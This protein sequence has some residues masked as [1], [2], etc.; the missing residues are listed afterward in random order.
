MPGRAADAILS[1]M[2]ETDST[3]SPQ[4]SSFQRRVPEGDSRERLVC[5][6]CGFVNY[7]N[8]KI[9]VG[10]VATWEGRILLCRRAIHPRRGFWTLPAGYLELNETTA[11]GAAREAFEEACARIRIDQLL[12]VYSIPR[13]SQVQ[14]M[15]RADLVSPDVAAGEETEAV[16]LFEWDEIPWEEIAFPSVH[17]ALHHHRETRHEAAFVPR[18]NPPGETGDMRPLPRNP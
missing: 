3:P 17:W 10:V 2:A 8:P 7:E 5:A 16:G 4:A 15:Y 12:A 18:S 14:L 13:I 9:V 1:G 11:D 6:D